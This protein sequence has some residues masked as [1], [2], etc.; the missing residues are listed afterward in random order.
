MCV[1]N[2]W[3][4][5]YQI[6]FQKRI[7]LSSNF[8]SIFHPFS[9]SSVLAFSLYIKV[10]EK[11]TLWTYTS[12]TCNSWTGDSAGEIL[13]SD[14]CQREWVYEVLRTGLL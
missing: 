2:V 7:N 4:S 14:V 8:H 3:Y 11:S 5:W 6:D 12:F 9:F 10:F 13:V 1:Y